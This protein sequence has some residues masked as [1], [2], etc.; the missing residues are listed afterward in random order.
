MDDAKEKKK[1]N[2]QQL[3]FHLP[4][5]VHSWAYPVSVSTFSDACDRIKVSSLHAP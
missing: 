4:Y 3:H 1:Y 2:Q 5:E